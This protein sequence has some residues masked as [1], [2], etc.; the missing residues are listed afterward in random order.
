MLAACVPARAPIIDALAAGVAAAGRPLEIVTSRH[1]FDAGYACS[2][3]I[4]APMFGPGRRR[5]GPDMVEPESVAVPD[6]EAGAIS[7]R[8]AIEQICC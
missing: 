2:I 6:C 5:F 4:P 3:G 1:T 7:L 8:T